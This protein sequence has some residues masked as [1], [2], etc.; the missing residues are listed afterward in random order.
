M[1]N[2]LVNLREKMKDTGLDSMLISNPDNRRYISGFTGSAGYL[3]ITLN[4]A[5]L[6]TDFRYIEQSTQQSPD[7]EIFR[8]SGASNKLMLLVF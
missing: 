6:A 3:L 5:I 4:E 7:F 1:N 2:R 8:I